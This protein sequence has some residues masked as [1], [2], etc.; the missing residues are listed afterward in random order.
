MPP[1]A[2]STKI[3]TFLLH[4]S[5]AFVAAIFI[6]TV[7]VAV[8]PTVSIV[9]VISSVTDVVVAAA[10]VTTL[11]INFEICITRSG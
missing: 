6:I 3:L 1:L 7:G 10:V 9:I 2:K 11:R 8:G 4:L 5:L